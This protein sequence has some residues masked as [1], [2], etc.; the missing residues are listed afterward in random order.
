MTLPRI[1]IGIFLFLVIYFNGLLK[2][3]QYVPQGRPVSIVENP[4][5]ES[6]PAMRQPCL[7]P[8]F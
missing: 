3:K 5:K 6:G 4:T 1:R 7:K 2:K 8:I